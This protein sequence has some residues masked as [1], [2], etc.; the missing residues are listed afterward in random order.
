[1]SHLANDLLADPT[2][3]A[4]A[5][6][7]LCAECRGRAAGLARL[8]EAMRSS[9]PA[10]AEPALVA[11]IVARLPRRHTTRRVRG[12]VAWPWAVA[13]A[14]AVLVVVGVLVARPRRAVVEEV[15]KER[16][17]PPPVERA[18]DL[19]PPAPPAPKTEAPP[20]PVEPRPEPAPE[21]KPEPK[22]GPKPEPPPGPRPEPPRESK[23]E[24]PAIALAKVEGPIDTRDART[25]RTKGA[26]A[27]L[28][29]ADGTRLSLDADTDVRVV[30]AAAVV[31]DRGALYAESRKLT[32]ETA[33]GETRAGDAKFGVRRAGDRTEVVVLEG[34]ALC[35]T[36]KGEQATKGGQGLTMA[37]GASPTK[38]RAVD[39]ERAVA[40]SRK[41]NPPERAIWRHD[42]ENGRKPANLEE[43]TVAAGPARFGNRFCVQASDYSAREYGPSVNFKLDD[44][45]GDPA[46]LKLRF[47]AHAAGAKL[48]I[49]LHASPVG[50][51]YTV[52]VPVR[53]GEWTTVEVPLSDLV[54]LVDKSRLGAGDKLNYMQIGVRKGGESYFD[55][56]ELTE[57]T[58]K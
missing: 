32:V 57:I 30:G 53:E 16:P 29:F 46:R 19:P 8:F 50:D 47:R 18:K 54:R 31:L 48:W 13:A 41:L 14:A 2:P 24:E 45:L 21:P 49:N 3:E 51:N 39:A 15:A 26:P 52:D 25:W 58:E 35:V 7:E 10:T 56:I 36:S 9:E 22:P 4:R 28:T 1:M 55:D 17:T 11:R 6:L 23:P 12:V 43:G 37:R 5:H 38:P 27:R 42:F 33:D 40:W 20:A 34:E 44:K